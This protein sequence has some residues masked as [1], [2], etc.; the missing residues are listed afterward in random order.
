MEREKNKLD[1]LAHA[2]HQAFIESGHTL[3]VAESFTGGTI[4]S[5]LVAIPGASKFFREG[6]VCYSNDSKRFR[7]CVKDETLSNYGAVSEQT[8]REMAAGLLSSPLKPDYVIATT[9]NADVSLENT[10]NDGEAYVAVGDNHEITVKRLNFTGK[11]NENIALGAETA[12][13]TLLE[14]VKN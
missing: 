11:R 3:A 13:D 10:S 2:V 9:G 14:L 4:A 5:K 1:E 12:L 6:I 7:L 8:A